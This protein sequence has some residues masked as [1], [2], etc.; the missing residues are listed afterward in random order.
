[1]FQV[2]EFFSGIGAMHLAL[3]EAKINGKVSI[4]FDINQVANATYSHNFDGLKPTTKLVEHLSKEFFERLALDAWLLSPPCQPFT[5][6]GLQRDHLDPRSVG[7]LHLINVLRDIKV[8]PTFVFLENVLNFEVSECRRLLLDA[9][10]QR[11]FVF[12]EYLVSPMDPYIG[13]PN[14]RLRYYLI[15]R[16]HCCQVVQRES[17]IIRSFSEIYP[18]GPFKEIRPISAYLLHSQDDTLNVP[19]KY[20]TEYKN[21]RH[22]IV[23]PLDTKS[24][25][26][27]KAY[28][29]EYIIGTGSFLQT[30]NLEL[31]DYPKDDPETLLSLNLRFFGPKEI[32]SLHAFPDRFEFA[33]GTSRIQQYRLLGNS[34]NV[35]V[36]TVLLS[37]LFNEL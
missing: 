4:A 30:G 36:V 29:S 19:V 13:I 26:F 3:Q 11:G 21:Y 25:T 8:P 27:T 15:A 18:S 10:V 12:E 6:G 33:P 9:L 31:T 1:M 28:G 20:I 17:K 5:R 34:M 32:A 7:L 35:Q 2:G 37:R 22:D 24:T 23:H 16:R 14:D